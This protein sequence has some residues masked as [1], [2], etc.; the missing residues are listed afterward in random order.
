MSIITVGFRWSTFKMISFVN[1]ISKT[2]FQPVED[3]LQS[4][5]WRIQISRSTWVNRRISM[6]LQMIEFGR[7]V[8][9]KIIREVIFRFSHRIKDKIPRRNQSYSCMKRV[10]SNERRKIWNFSNSSMV[11]FW[12]TLKI[13]QLTDDVF[14]SEINPKQILLHQSVEE[15]GTQPW[16][17]VEKIQSFN[18]EKSLTDQNEKLENGLHQIF[19]LLNKMKNV[20]QSLLAG[21]RIHF[22]ILPSNQLFINKSNRFFSLFEIN[23]RNSSVEFSF[24]LKKSTIVLHICH[25]NNWN[26]KSNT[27]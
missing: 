25:W 2:R 21:Q 23:Y 17:M 15:I 12:S 4:V 24:F 10:I 3:H 14:V 26:I 18:L 22:R 8:N 7:T 27:P 6:K 16:L 11:R 5:E 9:S 1:Q 13:S 19:E 20:N